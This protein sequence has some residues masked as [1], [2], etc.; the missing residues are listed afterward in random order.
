MELLS[1]H[2]SE[3]RHG[4]FKDSRKLFF[5]P[6]LRSWISF[7]PEFVLEI[8]RDER[9]VVPNTLQAVERL[10][11]HFKKPFPNLIFAARCIPLLVEGSVHRDIRRRLA[12]FLS[13][14]RT[15]MNAALPQ[16]KEQYLE[17]LNGQRRVEW[18]KGCLAPLVADVFRHLCG[19]PTPLPFPSLVISRVFDR[20]ASLA[21]YKEV[22]QQVGALRERIVQ[23][24]PH[25]DEQTVFAVLV[26]G[27]DAT[28]GTLATSLATILRENLG[29]PLADVNFPDYP[30]ETGVAIAER[31]AAETI[32]VDD[33][34]IAAGDRIRLYYQPISAEGSTIHRQNLFGS[35]PHSCLGRPISLDL[36]RALTQKLRQFSGRVTSVDVEFEPNTVFVVPRYLQTGH[37]P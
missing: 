37:E 18:I 21:V 5:S 1:L 16:L 25:L 32:R 14:G 10:E 29:R 20:F 9:L 4:E 34:T 33:V 2:Y 13:E 11:Q 27:R 26:L 30:P 22:E 36:W 28:L 23:D 17:P 7:D 35:G 8:L 6:E 31:F 24:L 3:E 19:F 15:R 12:E